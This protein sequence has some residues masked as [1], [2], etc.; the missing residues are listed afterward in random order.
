MRHIFLPALLCFTIAACGHPAKNGTTRKGTPKITIPPIINISVPIGFGAVAPFPPPPVNPT[1]ISS[2]GTLSA[3]NPN[4][5][6]QSVSAPDLQSVC[7]K[8]PNGTILDQNGFTVKGYIDDSSG[9][10]K[11]DHFYSSQPGA[12]LLCDSPDFQSGTVRTSGTS[13]TWMSGNPFQTSGVWTNRHIVINGV[14]ATVS[15]VLDNH[16]LTV[17]TALPTQAGVSYVLGHDGCIA[18]QSSFSPNGSNGVLRVDH[19]TVNNAADPGT[20]NVTSVYVADNG[21]A[22]VG[23]NKDDGLEID[24]ISGTLN[25]APHA[26]RSIFIYPL[27]ANNKMEVSDEDITISPTACAGQGIQALAGNSTGTAVNDLFQY[28]R[29]NALFNTLVPGCDSDRAID[30]DDGDTQKI[31]PASTALVSGNIIFTYNNRCFRDRGVTNVTFTGNM[32]LDISATA[33]GGAVHFADTSYAQSPSYYNSISTGNL[34]T[35][36]GPGGIVYF[37]RDA[38]GLKAENDLILGTSG[39]M[40]D[41][42]TPGGGT[43]CAAATESRSAGL[44][45]VTFPGKGESAGC[46]IATTDTFDLAGASDPSFNFTAIVPLTVAPDWSSLTFADSCKTNCAV[47]ATGGKVARY[48]QM[49]FSN[50]VGALQLATNSTAQPQTIVKNCQAAAQAWIGKGTVINS[51]PPCP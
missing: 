21:P 9:G 26:S 6:T 30:I 17:S 37:T 11:P 16:D 41:V 36:D 43:P 19:I 38:G 22:E 45:T 31:T 32:C 27:D 46:G 28:S 44:V 15:S 29:I 33:S 20:N 10:P 25:S 42:Y 47:R 2:C 8:A 3:A 4:Q 7:F 48:S 49:T 34:F 35:I 14:Q 23:G 40:A 24:H 18:I 39:A 50:I 12:Q 1:L 5:L 51:A 13:V